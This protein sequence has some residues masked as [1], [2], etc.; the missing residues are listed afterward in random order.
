MPDVSRRTA[1]HLRPDR[2]VGDSVLRHTAAA[3]LSDLTEKKWSDQL[4]SL[5][6]R[7]PGLAVQLGWRLNYHVHR[8]D[9]SPAGY[10]DWTIARERIIFAELKRQPAMSKRDPTRELSATSIHPL[11]DL[12][13]RFLDGF[14][15]AA[16]EVYVWVPSDLE[17][18]KEIL[19]KRWWFHPF[20]GDDGTATKRGLSTGGLANFWTPA[21]MWIPGSGRFDGRRL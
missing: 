3:A 4:F 13:R 14:A 9:R 15:T 7:N 20:A 1:P 12:Q 16:G 2:P 19:S 21:S 8:A 11:S 17:E 6:G 18:I 5:S 10:P